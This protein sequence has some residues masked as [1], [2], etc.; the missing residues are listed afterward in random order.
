MSQETT[1]FYEPRRNFQKVS[2]VDYFD[3][4]DEDN[5]IGLAEWVKG[6]KT[7]PCPFGKKEPE[8][9]DFDITKADKIFDLLLQQGQIKLSQFHTI[10][11]TEELKRMKYCKWH[12]A[13]SHDTYDCKIIRQQIQSAIEQGKLKFETPA[14]AEKPMKI[15]QRPFP[16]NT[17]EVSSK[18]TSRVK[19]LTSESAQN[20]G[21]VDPK[22]QAT[23]ADVKGKGLLLEEDLKPCG[24]VTSQMLINKF[25]RRQEK[26]REREEWDRCNE[27]HLRCLFFK[28]CWEEGI[29]LPTAENCS[30]CNRAYNNSSSSKR[31][32]FND[33][34]PTAGDHREFSN[35]RVLVYDRLGG[36]A[37][38][39]DRLGGKAS[40]YDRLG[41]RVNERS[42]GRLEEMADSL[43]LD[44]DIMCRAPE[45]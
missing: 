35:Q 37:S 30:K 12:N 22:V 43:V 18:D 45:R 27:G 19:L 44:E 41:G 15:D 8:K 6:K 2:Y 20:K 39:Y 10:S 16:S 34:R 38:V 17:V 11:S 28:Y 4:E 5:M 42:N 1:K 29:K 7:V 23:A 13:T 40:I 26:A 21:V 24:P 33:R 9:F 3:P 32:Y 36:K 14:K 25:Q 31:V